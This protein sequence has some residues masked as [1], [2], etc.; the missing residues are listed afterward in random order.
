MWVLTVSHPPV[1]QT[2]S[3]PAAPRP[4]CLRLLPFALLRHL[5]AARVCTAPAWY[6]QIISNRCVVIWS[7]VVTAAVSGAFFLANIDSHYLILYY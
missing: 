4:P 1:C 3:A 2:W 6:T 7:E 5:S